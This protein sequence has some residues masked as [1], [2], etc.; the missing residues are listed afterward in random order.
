MIQYHYSLTKIRQAHKK[1]DSFWTPLDNAAK[2]FPAVRSKEHTTILRHTA[3]LKKRIVIGHLMKAIKKTEERFPYFKVSLRKGFFW[4]YLEHTDSPT[5]V[6]V[7]KDLPCRAFKQRDKLLFRILVYK[8]RISLEISHIITD[9][10]GVSKFLKFLLIHYFKEM[11]VLQPDEY[12][13]LPDLKIDKEEFEDAYSRYFKENLPTVIHQPKAFHLPFPLQQKP[14]FDVLIA[15]LSIDEL[16]KKSSER[17]VS[18]TDYLVSIYLWVLQEIIGDLKAQNVSVR[19]KILRIQV[20]IN[21]RNIY[22]SKSMRNFSLFVMPEIDLRLGHYTFDEIVKIVYHKM[23]LETDEKLINK[24]L[25]RNVGGEKNLF[26]RGI[27]L[28]IKS[29][30]LNLKYYSEGANQYSGVITNLGM[31]KLPESIS[32]RI[33]YFTITPPPPNRILKVNCGVVGFK[34]KLVLSF[35]NITKSKEIEKRIIRFLTDQGIKIK[36]TKY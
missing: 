26:V 5:I 21:L 13:S 28:L 4:Y 17:N 1:K 3:V 2:I 22:P 25:S 24:I 15:I 11:G 31:V 32:D 27:P 23:Q 35:G 10:Y 29:L 30:V 7:D 20:P 9:G 6:E 14:R 19:N 18:I 36:I 12:S 8:N 34:D 33:D 16:K